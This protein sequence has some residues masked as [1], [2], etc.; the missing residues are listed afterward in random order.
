LIKVLIFFLL[1]STTIFAQAQESNWF[2]LMSAGAGSSIHDS[3]DTNAIN[4]KKALGGTSRMTATLDMPVFY[5]RL[6]SNDL[7]GA[8]VRMAMENIAEN[9][10]AAEALVFHNYNYN[11][12][13]Q[14][15]LNKIGD[16]T[17]LRLDAGYSELWR[18]DKTG[19]VYNS[20]R[21]TGTH[22]ELG[23]GYGWKLPGGYHFLM[24][25]DQTYSDLG[26][27]FISGNSVYVAFLL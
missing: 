26:T 25:V 27:H 21:F 6:S 8:G 13:Y 20:D 17:F 9:W 10:Q 18:L 11:V 24:A 4:A 12:S 15:W 1:Y 16:G 5:V 14:R 7:M 23:V 2:V 22:S 3:V 19:G